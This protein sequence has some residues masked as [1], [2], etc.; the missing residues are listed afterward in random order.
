MTK[1]QIKNSIKETNKSI[2]KSL[3][4]HRISLGLTGKQYSKTLGISIQQLMKYE[5]GINR[6]CLARLFLLVK[7]YGEPIGDIYLS[8]QTAN[9]PEY[10]NPKYINEKFDIVLR[11]KI[12][13]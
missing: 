5:K 10:V 13:N 9:N 1:E 12:T 3:R 6:V 2:G 7:E 11:P 4:A 8:L